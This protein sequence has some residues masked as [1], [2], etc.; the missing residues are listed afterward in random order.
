[1][2]KSYLEVLY[3]SRTGLIDQLEYEGF[4]TSTSKVAVDYV[5]PSWKKQAAG[6]AQSYVDTFGYDY[7]TWDE[8]YDQ[9][10]WEG[11]TASE[12][13]YGVESVGL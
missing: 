13:T 10:R 3:F 8:L 7:F 9:L 5:N 12:A 1:M 6:S 2:A 4:N 11:F